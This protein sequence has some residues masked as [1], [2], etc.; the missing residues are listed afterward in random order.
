MSKMFSFITDTWNPLSG[1]CS[2]Q[3]S[4]CWAR[5]LIEKKKFDRFH[6]EPCLNLKQL[7]RR[8]REGQFIFTQD[9]TDLFASNV[10]DDLIKTILYRI[11]YSGATFLLLTKNPK[12]Y[13]DL[14]HW[15]PDNV[16]LG[17]TI[18]S[19]LVHPLLSKAPTQFER[20]YH[21]STLARDTKRRLFISIEPILDFDE[22]RFETEI[23]CIK[24][25]GVAIGYDNYKHSLQE[26]TL[27][28]TLK[29]IQELR[30]SGI[31]VYEKTIRK[32][33]NE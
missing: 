28:K 29:L 11:R 30:A 27:G 18:E 6:G 15:L 5:A 7:R 25:W 24:P 17:C 3:C 10:E 12:C 23:Y 13:L 19:N 31:Q 14:L 26:P 21:M 22:S 9:M 8:F 32:A 16:I 2:H 20:L 4:Y 33:W 1:E